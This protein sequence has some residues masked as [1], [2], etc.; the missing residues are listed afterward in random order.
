MT[1]VDVSSQLFDHKLLT[2]QKVMIPAMIPHGISANSVDKRCQTLPQVRSFNTLFLSIN[3][4]LHS[5]II[6]FEIGSCQRLW[7]NIYCIDQFK[8]RALFY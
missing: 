7:S 1:P 3:F 8:R 2:N 5:I 4:N 6:G